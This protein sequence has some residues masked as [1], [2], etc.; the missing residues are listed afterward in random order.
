[1]L[2]NLKE[3]IGESIDL[4]ENESAIAEKLD[5]LLMKTLKAQNAF[6][7]VKNP[8]QGQAPKAKAPKGMTNKQIQTVTGSQS[9]KPAGKVAN[10][11]ELLF[12]TR[13]VKWIQNRE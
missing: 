12:L 10:T 3:D 8:N 4:S 13:L 9:K 5:G 6:S 11:S 1:M 7:P 2:Y